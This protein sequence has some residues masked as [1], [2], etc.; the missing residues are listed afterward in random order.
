MPSLLD[1]VASDEEGIAP[2]SDDEIE[3][4]IGDDFNILEDGQI[5]N[6]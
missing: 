3:D 1:E 6:I 4:L 5:F 2:D